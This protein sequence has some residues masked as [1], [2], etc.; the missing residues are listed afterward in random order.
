MV[1]GSLWRVRRRDR[2]ALFQL[3]G[4][5][6]GDGQHRLLDVEGREH[7]FDHIVIDRAR[8]SNLEDLFALYGQGGQPQTPILLGGRLGAIPAAE[9][10]PHRVRPGSD[11]GPDQTYRFVGIAGL[12]DSVELID[13]G[14]ARGL[15][16]GCGLE[17]IGAGIGA[18]EVQRAYQSGQGESLE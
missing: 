10:L 14:V 16:N 4:A 17:S 1:A 18:P 2:L 11:S 15:Q 12:P 7:L 9:L 5:L 8:R 6:G 13:G 3:L